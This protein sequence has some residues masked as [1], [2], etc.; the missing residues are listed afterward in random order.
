MAV[1]L[2]D[3]N[4]SATKALEVSFIPGFLVAHEAQQLIAVH[5]WR[6]AKDIAGLG[7]IHGAIDLIAKS[8]VAAATLNYRL[9]TVRLQVNGGAAASG[10][11]GAAGEGGS[12]TAATAAAAA[13]PAG[14]FQ[15]APTPPPGV[16]PG[17]PVKDA[18]ATKGGPTK[19]EDAAA[20]AA[21]SAIATQQAEALAAAAAAAA[22]VP[23]NIAIAQQLAEYAAQ[24]AAHHNCPAIVL[25]VGNGQAGK[26]LAI[27]AVCRE[28]LARYRAKFNL[29]CMKASGPT[30]RPTA[31]M[32]M[33]ALVIPGTS[34][35]HLRYALSICSAKKGD[36]IGVM[37]VVN[38]GKTKPPEGVSH[39]SGEAVDENGVMTVAEATRQC[40]ALLADYGLSEAPPSDPD[41]PPSA[42]ATETFPLISHV[43]LEPTNANPTPT[44][45]ESGLQLIKIVGG[46][47]VDFLVLPPKREGLS[48]A[49][50][51]LCLAA[52]KPH[53]LLVRD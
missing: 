52:P 15:P 7:A 1:V 37:V 40:T 19:K 39:M 6:D 24:R 26:S 50:V 20:A 46:L 45:D 18:K 49:Y 22:D 28:L 11:G 34:L 12:A 16:A 43:A 25:G 38:N 9:E 32:R 41:A 5:G 17:S 35:D 3:G 53:V 2:T 48:D 10:Q 23:E 44:V 27:G 36:R 47:K 51:Q 33:M 31:S 42:A 29:F 30:V 21:A 13:Q 4:A 14:A 8:R